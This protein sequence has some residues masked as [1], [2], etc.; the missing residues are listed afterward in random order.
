MYF[1]GPDVHCITARTAQ[2]LCVSQISLAPPQGL[3]RP[4]TLG[5]V[6]YR[7]PESHH[8]PGVVLPAF[9]M[10]GQPSRRAVGPNRL[11]IDGIGSSGAQGF[12][13]HALQ[14]SPTLRGEQPRMFLVRGCR[15]IGG[16]AKNSISL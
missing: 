15:K 5:D 6:L 11:Q 10:G 7:A 2:L 12:V 14:P 9:A 3:L 4:L 8:S 16:I 1:Q 13:D